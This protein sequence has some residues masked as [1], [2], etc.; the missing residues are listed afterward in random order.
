MK[1][2]FN[3]LFLCTHNSARSIMAEAIL[4]KIAKGKFHAY[5]AGSASVRTP[6]LYVIDRL[7]ALGHDTSKYRSKSWNEFTGPDAPRMD[8]VFT[9]CD[10]L[11]DQRCPDFGEQV[12][13]A[14]WPF[15]DPAKFKG[16]D[17]ER[18]TLINALYGMIRRRLEVFINLPYATLDSIAL[19][20]R[21][22]E[23]GDSSRF[24]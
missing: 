1:P 2:A 13:T 23:L 16:S 12:V 15:P 4:A 18:T 5:S 8:F 14:A 9:L 6:M 17:I 3:V 22:D 19:K 10:T 11:D 20:A 21:L 7:K 24:D